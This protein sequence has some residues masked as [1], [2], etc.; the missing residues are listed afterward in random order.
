MR[1]II[2]IATCVLLVDGTGVTPPEDA[3]VFNRV[4]GESDLGVSSPKG[5]GDGGGTR[6][7][8]DAERVYVDNRGVDRFVVWETRQ[9]D[10]MNVVWRSPNFFG[11][12]PKAV[13][14][15]FNGDGE[16]DL[17]FS[18]DYRP[19]VGGVWVFRTGEGVQ[20]VRPEFAQCRM[21][22]VTIMAED[23]AFVLYAPAVYRA[24]Q[25]GQQVPAEACGAEFLTEWPRIF[26]VRDTRV[27]EFT[28]ETGYYR[29][30]AERY[31]A[32]A[33]RADSMLGARAMIRTDMPLPGDEQPIAVCGDALAEQ[34][35]ALSDSAGQLA[36]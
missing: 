10:S 1:T 28:A 23:Y 36:R 29:Q 26:R 16:N 12:A 4:A 15:D 7:E 5:A 21:A 2:A 30:L 35:R 33:R 9:A 13:L 32:D 27:E 6:Q 8:A 3:R 22:D 24:E 14:D 11:Y 25:C 34:L 17:F 20:E 31:A 19:A 18:T